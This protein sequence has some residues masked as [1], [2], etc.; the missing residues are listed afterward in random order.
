MTTPIK[1][2]A[3]G[4]TFEF[5]AGTAVADMETAL[6][7]NEHLIN[8]DFVE[9]D[10]EA[11]DYAKG[12]ASG[13]NQLVSGLGYLA[14]KA[15]AKETGASVRAFGDRGAKYWN[16]QM[17]RGGKRAAESQVF[18]DDEDS[19]LGVRLSDDWG[20]SMLM[21]A[22]QSL[23]SM[24]AAALPGVAITKGIQA[25]AR[26]GL[27]GGAG[28][29]IPL[30]A[31]TAAPVGVASSVIARA[32]SAIGF[33]MAEGVVG[34]ATNAAQFKSSIESMDDAELS[35]SPVYQALKSE[36]GPEQAR[37]LLADQA[38]SD[39][40]S[41]T[42]LSTGTI[43]ALTGG[44]ALAQAYQKTTVGAGSGL[45]GSIFKGA[46]SEF[47]QETPQSGGEQ[48]I[49]NLTTRD[50]LDPT[51]DP[52]K[53][54]LAASLSGGAV[55]GL[56]GGVVGGGGAINLT[57]NRK[58]QVL[59]EVQAISK[60][61]ADAANARATAD[62]TAGI[63]AAPTLDAAIEAAQTASTRK[64]VTADDV[65]HEADP[66][67]ADIERLTGLKPTEALE[68]ARIDAE[69]QA[70]NPQEIVQ[71]GN[72][73]E[74][75]ATTEAP[76][77]ETPEAL[78][79]KSEEGN[80]Y[81]PPAK[82]EESLAQAKLT[83]QELEEKIPAL[84][85]ALRTAKA[86]KGDV[87]LS[88]KDIAALSGSPLGDALT[89]KTS[90]LPKGR[91]APAAKAAAFTADAAKVHESIL[92]SLNKAGKFDE[93]TNA[94]YAKPFAEFYKVNAERQGI[95]PSE[96]YKKMPL[97]F[98]NLKGKDGLSQSE[99]DSPAVRN[100]LNFDLRSASPADFTKEGI[101]NLI[102]AK[103]WTILTAGNPNGKVQEDAANEA[104]NSKLKADLEARGLAYEVVQGMYPNDKSEAE[105]Y[106]VYG[107]DQATAHEL[108]N[109][110]R[111]D[112]VLTREGLVH[113]NGRVTPVGSAISYS[114][115]RDA[116][117][118]G[119]TRV[120]RT[121]AIFT[122]ELDWSKEGKV[123][124]GALTLKST[125]F[126]KERRSTLEAKY[127]GTGMPAAERERL[128]TSEDPRIQKRVDFYVDTGA[129]VTPEAGLGGERHDVVL[130]NIYDASTNPLKFKA[131]ATFDG[132]NKFE[133]QV[134][135]AGFDGYFT[136][137]GKQGRVVVMGDAAKSIPTGLA[138]DKGSPEKGLAQSGK[139]ATDKSE[140]PSK[141][142][143]RRVV[144][145]KVEQ[146]DA[147]TLVVQH[148]L[149][150]KNLIHADRMGGLAAPSIGIT[151]KGNPLTGFGEITLIADKNLIDPKRGARTFGSDVYSPRYPEVALS[152]DAASTKTINNI[153]APFVEELGVQPFTSY[154]LTNQGSPGAVTRELEYNP[155][156]LAAFLTKQGVKPKYEKTA[157]RELEKEL[158]IFAGAT[159]AQT[160]A[161]RADFRK[162]VGRVHEEIL[163]GKDNIDEES[164]GNLARAE[165]HKVV[166]YTKYLAE[167]GKID[168]DQSLR[169]MRDQ[170]YK[171]KLSGKL[172]AFTQEVLHK[173]LPA[174]RIFKGFTNAG[175]RKYIPHTI[176]NVVKELKTNIRGGENFN[177]GLG[178]VR[179]AYTPQFKSVEQIKAAKN[180]L[181][182]AE[183]FESVK[184]EVG[185][186]LT[187]L[188]ERLDPYHPA[189]RF[190]SFATAAYDAA[191]MGVS[192]ALTENGYKG[193]PSEL[194]ADIAEFLEKLRGMP[195]EYFESKLPRIVG[196][197]E[198]AA[199]VVPKG[200]PQNALDIL[201][202]N[203]ITDIKYY[204]DSADRAKKIGSF[205][206]LLFQSNFYS[207]LERNIDGL[208]KVANKN[209]E[210]KVE[211]AKAWI[212]SRMKEGLFKAEEVEAIGLLDW[213][214][215]SSPSVT[216]DAVAQ[217]VKNNGVQV[218]DVIHD[219]SDGGEVVLDVGDPEI[220]EPD[221]EYIQE[222]AEEVLEEEIAAIAEN[223]GVA[224][225]EVDRESAL[226]IIIHNL[227]NDYYNNPDSPQSAPAWV[228]IGGET[229]DYTVEYS[230]GETSIYSRYEGDY[231]VQDSQRGVDVEQEI[232]D[233]AQKIHDKANPTAI[234][235]AGPTQFGHYTLR[236]GEDYKELALVLPN[237][238]V[239]HRAP[240]VHSLSDEADTNRAVHIRFNTREVPRAPTPEMLAEKEAYKKE[241]AEFEVL[242]AAIEEESKAWWVVKEET[243]AKYKAASDAKMVELNDRGLSERQVSDRF[244]DWTEKLS[245]ELKE[246][247]LRNFEANEKLRELSQ[248][249]KRPPTPD[250]MIYGG[251][252]NTVLFI[253]EIQSDWAQEGR[254]KG[255]DTQLTEEQQARFD[256]LLDIQL[257]DSKKL[258]ALKR[259]L[260]DLED[261]MEG[262]AME[263]KLPLS[264]ERGGILDARKALYATQ[265]K[266][267]NEINA[268]DKIRRGG[269][270]KAPFVTDTKSWT[271][272]ALKRMIRYAA[273]N[274]FDSIAWTSGAQQS[275]RYDLSK[276]VSNIT[277][278]KAHGEDKVYHL[279]VELENGRT[280][281]YT[282]T[283]ESELAN[284][285]GADLADKIINH[286]DVAGKGAEFS[287]LDLQVGG[288]GM[289]AFYDQ[290]VPQ[291]A[292]TILKKLGGG[293]VQVLNA[294]AQ[295]DSEHFGKQLGFLITPELKEKAMQ[296]L[297]LF[298]QQRAGY[299]PQ[300]FTVSLMDG[301]DL[302]SVIH[303]G[304]HFYLEGLSE[305]SSQ[306]DAP[307]S[308]VDDFNTTL[309]WFGIKGQPLTG[310][311]ALRAVG[312]PKSAGEPL[313]STTK[314]EA[315]KAHKDYA[316]AKKGED[317]AA[318]SLVEALISKENLAE[319][320]ERFAGATFVPVALVD[321][322]GAN[323][324]PTAMAYHYANAVGG[325]VSDQIFETDK[326]YHTGMNAMERLVSRTNFSGKVEPGRKYVLVDDV[327]TV[328]S[329]LADL[330]AY[331]QSQGGEVI[332]SAL[333]SNATR[334]GSM[335]A[336]VKTTKRLGEQYGNEIRELFN[337]EPSALTN[338]EAQ[339]LLGFRSAAELRGSAAKAESSRIARILSKQVP[340]SESSLK[341]STPIETWNGMS[342]E[343]K[344]PYHEQWAQSFER[345]ALEGVAPTEEMQPVFDRFKAWM[346]DVYKSLKEFLKHNP[347]AGKLN[348][349]VRRV[350]DRL[351][352]S[353]KAIAETAKAR[354]A[355][356]PPVTAKVIPPP[357]PPGVPP[358]AGT[359]PPA[360]PKLDPN[361][362][363][364][365][366]KFRAAQRKTQDAFNRFTVIKEWL[367]EKG[368]NLSEKAD[369]FAAEE[370][371]H[372]KVANQLEDFREFERNPL[373]EKISKA[374]FTLSDVADY[375]EAQHAQEANKANRA[376]TGSA[377]STAYGITDKEAQDYLDKADPKLASLSNELRDIT[378]QSKKMRL[379]AGLL[380][381]DET[382]AW[383]AAYKH[384]IPVK[385]DADAKGGTGKGLK[386]QF[387]SKRRLGHGRRDEAVIENIFLDHERAIMQVEKNRVAKHLVLMAAEMAMPEIM[388]IGQP[389]KRK[390]L[391]SKTAYEVKVKGN[392][393][394]VFANREAAN[395]F[396]QL[397]P[398]L[399]KSVR[400]SDVTVDRTTDQRI[401]AQASPMLAE[402]ELNVYIDGHAIRIQI[403]DDL[404]ARAYGKLGVTGYSAIVNAGR[405]FNGYLS[406]VYTGYN[407]EFIITNIQRDFSSG[408]INLTG[409][410][411]IKM[412]A[413]AVGN[414]PKSFASLLKY[415]ASDRKSSDKWIDMYRASGGNTGA[416]YLSDLERLGEEVKTEYA[417][418]QGVLSNLKQGD[419]ANAARAAG[420]KVFKL[421]LKWIY[422]LNQAGENAM[423]LAAFRAMV[424]SGKTV[425][426]AARAA[427]NITVNFNRKGEV[428]A[429]LNAAYLFFNASV[430]GTAAL[431]HALTKGK[432]KY[433][434]WGLTGAMTT[435][436]YLAAAGLA[437]GDED[438]YDKV[439]DYTKSRNMLIK[440]GDGYV[441][442]PIPYGYGF[443]WNTGRALADAQRTGEMGVL[444]WHI[445]ASAIEELT[446]FSDT[447][448]G[449]DEGFHFDQVLLGMLPT[450][451]KI[452]A[453]PA[454]NTQLFSGGDLMPSRDSQKF[455]PEREMM[456]RGTQ[457]TIYDRM[458]GWLEE[459]IGADVSP[460][461]LKHYTRT[462]TG[463]AGA[464][465][466]TT[467]SA[468]MLK[469]QGAELDTAEIPFV[470]KAYTK[471]TIKDQRAAYYKATDKAR[472]AAEEFRRAQTRN[473][474]TTVEK[475][476]KDKKELLA[477]D[478][479][480]SSLSEL[481]GHTR[482]LQ[483]AIRVSE[484]YTAA[485][486]RTRIKELEI[487]EQTFYD[488]YLDVFKTRTAEMK[489]RAK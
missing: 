372:S 360:G 422:N 341:F 444:P 449:S 12:F 484:D 487:T 66:T 232:R 476:V 292:N 275:A 97:N 82:F 213:L 427:K 65:L 382:D 302:S 14:E 409:E 175:D 284:I 193:V 45:L 13:A 314:T 93:K 162:A 155:A 343:Q 104:A 5:P 210:V 29:T 330:A 216:V 178:S 370:R 83:P 219:D 182:S 108:G 56:M 438:D 192:K 264:I 172:E 43:G 59:K 320:K 156:F 89:G 395:M 319:A 112:S 441:Q 439:N 315:I 191:K 60:Q 176:E 307:K 6:K 327:T 181:L 131:P 295:E 241:L 48:Y 356:A 459:A 37:A 76:I 373:I 64:P 406:K 72:Q 259:E 123:P 189:S 228:E 480:A 407:P 340:G 71:N 84:A 402:N 28:A 101:P 454:L 324:I 447:V 347:L 398:T 405:A 33:G 365:E 150:V 408:I 279:D 479:F 299:N 248:Q 282:D 47:I 70:F 421:T 226:D 30:L 328:G 117:K 234:N 194:K 105:S 389:E 450:V 166:A 381:K 142:D 35:R 337:I 266:T 164:L 453:Q 488:K 68:Q 277:A 273:E 258:T 118:T 298:Q 247:N 432:H 25:L 200:T 113:H 42:A 157:K 367:A 36:H 27:A 20:K 169:A 359:V 148:N 288:E 239:S 274:G 293:K 250:W 349:D 201:K 458:A 326:A 88:R 252:K 103:D 357:M 471:L 261:R 102:S 126:S 371:Y 114:N 467:V 86:A 290:I 283:P 473:D 417:A 132:M 434:A 437:G 8:P 392:T 51:V 423:R 139:P 431:A 158:K 79:A 52:T 323:R 243:R 90:T 26:L 1:V 331:I 17:S 179:S 312:Y 404:L 7:D 161:Q 44:G 242:K 435:L 9:P 294:D 81:I 152:F 387:K 62:A 475:L 251:A 388:T 147:P 429:E 385:G 99:K 377:D 69:N 301:A 163:G 130:H 217:F 221:T 287:G 332:G 197:N 286:K 138:E 419:M 481:I 416:A 472:E 110:Y 227:T 237:L 21:G 16:D 379:A 289:K 254:K 470:R 296:G 410:E 92:S 184:T 19:K 10:P 58:A 430:Q 461:T 167:K 53:G 465:V 452:P 203:G 311:G 165:S 313:S 230:H 122:F 321:K 353:E 249:L 106:L 355:K 195:T 336:N 384:Y 31:G 214:D 145:K 183:Q 80:L 418:Y 50:Y 460:E 199:A 401:T 269:V 474:F 433:Q 342:L 361:T 94:V 190:D 352:A 485:E 267:Q 339:Y 140:A 257:E 303:E 297:P 235:S 220:D 121:G 456:W 85:K 78:T 358:M 15:G 443:F 107:V 400:I 478:D 187:A 272:L 168:P 351:I 397:L 346:L 95:T 338:E 306:P 363:I 196:L 144:S 428:G 399:D 111:Q 260:Y 116:D 67:L 305:M 135:D 206:K 87:K 344:R 281:N 240:S 91:V 369:V 160:L 451:L 207:A 455:Q 414:Y 483:D 218:E 208:L 209:G 442:I 23:P 368:V 41:K 215:V 75:Q 374:G 436:G 141:K 263:E 396:K 180:K 96:L 300:T 383:E 245:P 154:G 204:T 268:L 63:Q 124:Q 309:D 137:Q 270:P 420:R 362:D 393:R 74:N 375:L 246:N 202:K 391:T 380:S 46:G 32:P 128:Y 378:E 77:L 489:A 22:S 73:E 24:F 445:A 98:S 40:F 4:K 412:A 143:S 100:K 325:Q 205:E 440:A 212:N 170:I 262:L 468:A 463:G 278:R 225:D 171:K 49:Q 2:N 318:A 415:A 188:S 366:T 39:L 173:A 233:H 255:F 390:V 125:H 280:Q 120:P 223:E 457:G 469:S 386:V 462:F 425:N 466:D 424:E 174:E 238:E 127:M 11:A 236:G 334:S 322:E 413:K 18:V 186:G 317:R 3:Y 231:I 115:V 198:F 149:S 34:G 57:P 426:Q 55:G 335:F 403:N 308:I 345:Y 185:A 446:P 310:K 276:S 411:G 222:Q 61:K 394:S 177:Y 354:G 271:A 133:S 129:G 134:L 224:I 109:K 448:V 54:V 151:D 253:E 285:V 348:D 329:T 333:L 229:Y 244:Q 146:A 350:F 159:D 256:E 265:Q 464:M 119:Y 486:K 38:A 482:D 316:A 477:L 211:Q 364:P 153:I 291:V 136:K 376:L 304:A